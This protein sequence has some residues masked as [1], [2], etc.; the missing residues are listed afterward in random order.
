MNVEKI[1]SVAE[2]DFLIILLLVQMRLA[3]KIPSI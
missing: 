3:W 1:E 2:S